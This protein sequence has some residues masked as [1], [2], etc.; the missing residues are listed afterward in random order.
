MISKKTVQLAV[1][2]GLFI[3]ILFF[4]SFDLAVTITF[5]AYLLFSYSQQKKILPFVG[6]SLILLLTDIIFQYFDISFRFISDLSLDAYILFLSVVVIYFRS[7]KKFVEI[8]G[9]INKSGQTFNKKRLLSVLGISLIFGL[10]TFPLIGIHLASI[11]AYLS[12]SY[13]MK[14][15]DGKYAF[16][17]A[18]FFLII[19]PIFIILKKNDLSEGTAMFSFYFMIVGTIQETVRFVVIKKSIFEQL[20]SRIKVK[21]K[22]E[23]DV[24]DFRLVRLDIGRKFNKVFWSKKLKIVIILLVLT[25]LGYFIYSFIQKNNLSLSQVKTVVNTI[26]KKQKFISSFKPSPTATPTTLP[27]L[28]PTI[29]VTPIPTINISAVAKNFKIKVEN[30]TDIDGLAATTAAKLKKA[31]LINVDIGNAHRQDYQNWEVSTK[32]K[33]FDIISPLKGIL[34]LSNLSSSEATIPAGFDILIIAGR[35]K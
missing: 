20:L 30:G 24:S 14:R 7:E 19:S 2:C 3:A 32:R 35:N 17:I 29:T 34:E 6:I 31:G 10:L 5:S 33:D 21:E 12:F 18:L 16:I 9:K 13:L 1:Y 4:S 26:F 11:V 8:L 25:G 15:F 28:S 23:A 27:T 22:K